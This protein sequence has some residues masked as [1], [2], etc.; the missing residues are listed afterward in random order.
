[1]KVLFLSS[2][3][4]YMGADC[5]PGRSFP[6][7]PS[8]LS[9]PST[10]GPSLR[11]LLDDVL[12]CD[13]YHHRR[14]TQRSVSIHVGHCVPSRLGLVP[15]VSRLPSIIAYGV[16]AISTLIPSAIAHTI[17]IALLP[18]IHSK[19]STLHVPLNIRS[20]EPIRIYPGLA[21]SVC[22]ILRRILDAADTSR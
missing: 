9:R 19:P 16:P 17:A 1:M 21:V 14:S 6:R 4:S 20:F 13:S 3:W 22:P 12:S 2:H 15:S 5:V 18:P 10:L 8:P 7:F 11:H